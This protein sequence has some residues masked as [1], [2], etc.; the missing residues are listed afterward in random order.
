MP[1]H[2]L[3]REIARFASALVLL[4]YFVLVHANHRCGCRYSSP[5]PLACANIRIRGPLLPHI[6]IVGHLVVRCQE[7]STAP[8]APTRKQLFCPLPEKTAV[9]FTER[10][11]TA[12]L[13]SAG[14][15]RRKEAAFHRNS[16]WDFPCSQG[17]V[18]NSCFIFRMFDFF[19]VC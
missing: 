5:L 18:Q 16:L 1:A 2:A 9:L 19:V 7:A 6:R 12:V 3:L 8:C 4:Q 14:E 15:I 11:K 13:Y 17:G 10:G